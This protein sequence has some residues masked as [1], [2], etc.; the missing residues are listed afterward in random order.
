VIQRLDRETGEIEPYVTGPGG[1]IRP[2]PSPDGRW[3]AFVRRVRYQS[4]LYLMDIESG[5][6][7]PIHDGLD[8]DMQETWAIHGVYPTMSWTPDNRSIVFWAGGQIRRID[9]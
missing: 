9:I 5:R 7:I 4:V 1:S 3:L 2:T 8:R 6:E